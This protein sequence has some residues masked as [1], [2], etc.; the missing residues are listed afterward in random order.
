MAYNLVFYGL[1]GLAACEGPL[2]KWNHRR[3]LGLRAAWELSEELGQ[4]PVLDGLYRKAYV[5]LQGGRLQE[6]ADLMRKCMALSPDL[7]HLHF[8]LGMA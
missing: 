1:M 7:A 2:R 4:N 5:A 3:R 6:G 8:E